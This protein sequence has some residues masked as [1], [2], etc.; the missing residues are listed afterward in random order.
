MSEEMVVI[1]SYNNELEAGMA[2]A[3]LEASGIPSLIVADVAGSDAPPLQLGGQG[4]HLV[5][6]QRNLKAAEAA[7]GLLP[8]SAS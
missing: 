7:L 6:H 8:D 4:V 1:R 2:R 3:E 5:V